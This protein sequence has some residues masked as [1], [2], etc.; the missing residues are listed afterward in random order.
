MARPFR[1]V[2]LISIGGAV[3]ALADPVSGARRRHELRDRSLAAIRHGSLAL[4]QAAHRVQGQ[5]RGVFHDVWPGGAV[6]P[7]DD[8]TL[9]DRVRSEA[10]R[11]LPVTPRETNVGVVD[12]IVTLR[13]QIASRAAIE[14]L[15]NR[16]RNVPGVRGVENLLHTPDQAPPRAGRA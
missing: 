6:P 8:A 12:G 7:E 14:E 16:V 3:A 11:G 13:G 1:A 2:A 9:A 5:A 15:V 10:F 4:R